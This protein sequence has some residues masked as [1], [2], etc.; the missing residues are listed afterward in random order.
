MDAQGVDDGE[1][2]VDLVHAD[3]VEHRALP[4]AS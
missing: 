2:L 3:R 4:T 1:D